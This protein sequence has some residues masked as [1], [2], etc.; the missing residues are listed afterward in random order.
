MS[1]RLEPVRVKRSKS[2]SL[3]LDMVVM[4]LWPY[5]YHY[6]RSRLIGYGIVALSGRHNVLSL[7]Q[8]TA[9]WLWRC[10]TERLL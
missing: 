4:Y 10:C 3:L 8:V 7:C 2:P 1:K 5:L 9:D 6:V